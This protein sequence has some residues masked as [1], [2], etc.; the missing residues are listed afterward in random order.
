[1]ISKYFY[2]SI[3]WDAMLCYAMLCY[4]MLCYA[5]IVILENHRIDCECI[6]CSSSQQRPTEG[7]F[8]KGDCIQAFIQDDNEF[9]E[10]KF[11]VCK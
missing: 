8:F 4:A 7:H 5:A 11:E 3:T 6:S 10:D 1:M 2:I 9:W